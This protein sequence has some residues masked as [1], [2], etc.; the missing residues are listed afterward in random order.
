VVVVRAKT[1]DG[2]IRGFILEKGWTL[3]AKISG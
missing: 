2:I 3:G 1:D